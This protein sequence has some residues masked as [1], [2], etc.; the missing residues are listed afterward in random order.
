MPNPD[1]FNSI[2][3][4]MK[5]IAKRGAPLAGDI[6][7]NL[8]AAASGRAGLLGGP[9]L[10]IGGGLGDYLLDNQKSQKEAALKA[11]LK[12]QIA[13]TPGLSAGQKTLA[14][15]LIDAGQYDKIAEAIKAPPLA[16]VNF[17]GGGQGYAPQ[18]AGPLPTGETFYVKPSVAS[19]TAADIQA[20]R[21]LGLSTDPAQWTAPQARAISAQVAQD[22]FL[23]EPSPLP[24]IVPATEGG[25]SGYVS[26]PRSRT[27]AVGKPTFTA[28]GAGVTAGKPRASES[29]EQRSNHLRA[30]ALAEYRALPTTE[31]VDDNGFITRTHVLDGKPISPEQFVK[32]Y[33][34]ANA[35]A[36]LAKLL[37][38]TSTPSV[39]R[40]AASPAATINIPGVG[41]GTRI[42]STPDGRPIYQF[43]DGRKLTPKRGVMGSR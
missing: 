42:G 41:V 37:A 22:K 2:G 28:F 17:K 14:M 9:L 43:P 35:P 26:I 19:G 31:T 8:P 6:L 40:S 7:A 33:M 18:V 30:Q 20:A 21:E 27:G 13:K 4:T 24:K 5:A 16:Q 32:Q 38:P 23:G 12:A 39:S 36:S 34:E 10:A 1:W 29:P 15:T 11:N 3:N 25:V